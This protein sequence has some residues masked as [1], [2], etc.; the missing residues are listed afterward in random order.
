[1]QP[2]IAAL[3]AS[4]ERGARAAGR[5]WPAASHYYHPQRAAGTLRCH[6]RQRAHDD[7]FSH[8][9]LTDITSWVDFTAVAE[10]ADAAGFQVA[11]FATQAAFLL[12]GGIEAHLARASDG[13]S[14]RERVELAHGARQLLLPGE[15]GESFK[16]ML[17][18]KGIATPLSGMRLQD[19]RGS[20]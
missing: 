10:A 11:G 8:P 14:E 1:M 3:G 12:G 17:L 4:L 7:A 5:L 6:F 19:L 20:L 18:A 2:W 9:G 16:V 13:A 15:M